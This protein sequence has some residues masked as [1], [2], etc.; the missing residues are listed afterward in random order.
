MPNE[1]TIQAIPALSASAEK[2]ADASGEPSASSHAT[3][4]SETPQL[5][6]NPTLQFNSTLGLL[7]IQFRDTQGNITTSIPSQRQ[8]QAYRLHELPLPG[9]KQATPHTAGATGAH[10]TT[11]AAGTTQPTTTAQAAGVQVTTP[12][13]TPVAVQ[14]PVVSQ[15][16]SATQA[17]ALPTGKT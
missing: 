2:P 7:V 13:Q 17:P 9:Q 6:V 12:T 5:F 15:A 1:M 8:L 3:P 16:S 14:A 10:T 4:G 11:Q